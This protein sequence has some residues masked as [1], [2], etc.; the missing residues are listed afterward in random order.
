VELVLRHVAVD[1]GRLA[2]YQRVCGFRVGDALPGTYPHVLAFPLTL[3]LMTRPD[4]P[5][6]PVGIVHLANRISVARTLDAG[7]VVDLRVHAGRARPH[8]RGRQV[9]VYAEARVGGE[10]V[11]SEVSTY[12]HRSSSAAAP[13]AAPRDAAER[14]AP[15]VPTALWRVDRRVGP[16]YARV[17]GDH[18]PIHTSRLGA[19]LL[20]F[21]RPIAHG[22]WSKA[23]C[24]A[25]LEGRLPPAYAV[26]VAFKAPVLLPARVAFNAHPEGAGGWA[27]AVH[28]ARSGKPHLIGSVTPP[29]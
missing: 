15:P 9:N 14:E 1:R 21:R 3:S 20:G 6:P 24:L 13:A 5:L 28:D 11:W 18:N 12:L 17:S 25:A 10:P 16:A 27:L 19:R 22:M 4:F 2:A 7:E 26:D 8:P 23:R 29:G